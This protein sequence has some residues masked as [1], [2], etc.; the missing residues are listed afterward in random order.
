MGRDP[1]PNRQP[2]RPRLPFSHSVPEVGNRRDLAR[3]V[4]LFLTVANDL[5]VANEQSSQNNPG[6]LP[7]FSQSHP[8]RE[9]AKFVIPA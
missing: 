1:G 5:T 7:G 9:V 2:L 4:R 3:L 6:Q 8:L